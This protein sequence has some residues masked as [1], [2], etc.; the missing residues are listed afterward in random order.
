MTYEREPCI[1]PSFTIYSIRTADEWGRYIMCLTFI[2]CQSIEGPTPRVGTITIYGPKY[3]YI[4][5]P[6]CVY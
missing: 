3:I 4:Y 2:A 6:I 5:I 1:R